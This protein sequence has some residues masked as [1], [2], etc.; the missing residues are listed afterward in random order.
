MYAPRIPTFLLQDTLVLRR[1]LGAGGEGDVW[2]DAPGETVRAHVEAKR[3]MVRSADGESTTLADAVAYL[4]PE[5]EPVPVGTL[6]DWYGKTYRVAAAGA[7]PS[8]VR[9]VYREL[10]LEAR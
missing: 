6:V 2:E 4:R 1:W 5:V 3:R 7:L 8:E 10:L 9:P